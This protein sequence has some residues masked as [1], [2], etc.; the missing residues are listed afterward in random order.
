[1]GSTHFP[2]RGNDVTHSKKFT[3]LLGFLYNLL[4]DHSVLYRYIYL[5][6]QTYKSFCIRPFFSEAFQ[7]YFQGACFCVMPQHSYAVATLQ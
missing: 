4:K 6:T 2:L 1:M 5:H 3:I 7:K